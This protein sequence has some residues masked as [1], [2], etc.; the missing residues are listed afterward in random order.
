VTNPGW[1]PPS[2]L[3]QGNAGP[4]WS[5]GPP[6]TPIPPQRR[7]WGVAA[8]LVALNIGSIAAAA[9]IA[10]AIGR[11]SGSVKSDPQTTVAASSPD[12]S[13]SDAAA[14]KE[15]VC[16]AIDAG[17]RGIGDMGGIVTN[18]DLNIPVVLRKMNTIMAVNDSLSPAVPADVS[19][20]AKKYVAT[21]TD[22]TTAALAHAPVDQLVDLAKTGNIAVDAFYD[23]CGLPH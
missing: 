22:L 19:D 21:A 23:A 12:V 7:R 13:A 17:Q 18:G 8:M 10:Y 20:A 4:P 11:D 14:A 5:G 6:A 9:T 15:K 16:H 3:H 2:A 1:S